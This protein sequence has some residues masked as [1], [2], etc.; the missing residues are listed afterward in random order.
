MK[1][2]SQTCQAM[3]QS[4][5]ACALGP[6][7]NSRLLVKTG[8]EKKRSLFRFILSKISFLILYHG[9]SWDHFC[10]YCGQGVLAWRL[11]LSPRG[12]SLSLNVY[13]C[14]CLGYL[15]RLA[16]EGLPR[17]CMKFKMCQ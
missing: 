14:Q 16:M 4:S 5:F 3:P 15:S 7:S 17:V 13:V 8:T 10:R 12:M 11:S 9:E 2:Q 1:W 6:L